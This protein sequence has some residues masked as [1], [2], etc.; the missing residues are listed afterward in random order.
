MGTQKGKVYGSKRSPLQV[1]KKQFDTM[2]LPLH[3]MRH[4]V[5]QSVPPSIVSGHL[6]NFGGTH[7]HSRGGAVT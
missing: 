5:H 7:L 3:G 6:N 1:L 2:F 4:V